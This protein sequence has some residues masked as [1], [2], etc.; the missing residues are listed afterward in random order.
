MIPPT[1]VFEKEV[2]VKGKEGLVG[3]SR[4]ARTAYALR[5]L[6]HYPKTFI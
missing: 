3:A 6:P 1:M 4:I 2:Y 5:R